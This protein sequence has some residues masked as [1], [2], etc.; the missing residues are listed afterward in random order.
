MITN[1]FRRTAGS[2]GSTLSSAR[3]LIWMIGLTVFL[4]GCAAP[5]SEPVWKAAVDGD[6]PGDPTLIDRDQVVV[7]NLPK[8]PMGNQAQYTVFGQTYRVL[9]TAKDFKEWG[10]ATWYGSKFHGRATASG[11]I[12]DMHSLT[13]A[14]RHLPLPTF[15]RVTRIDNDRS[16]VV[17]VN[18]RGP[19]VHDRVIDLSYAAA[20]KLDMLNDGKAD[21]YIEALSHHE[22]ATELMAET[23]D[24]VGADLIVAKRAPLTTSATASASNS[25]STAASDAPLA[26][27]SAAT[28]SDGWTVVD[29][30]AVSGAATASSTAAELPASADVQ[31]AAPAPAVSEGSTDGQGM[32]LV[33][34]VQVGAYS[35]RENAERMMVRLARETDLPV[36]VDFDQINELYRVRIGPMDDRLNTEAALNELAETGIAGYTVKAPGR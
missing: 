17:K 28:S 24:N 20:A 18:D 19:F 4:S 14:H 34:Y 29:R 16:V 36:I 32:R 25:A 8:S 26:A 2:A 33:D 5:Q 10:T 22:G 31:A 7:R 12:Y 13:A 9:D 35:D 21:V 30:T 27:Q 15:V 1:C 23:D 6:G 3:H 11:E